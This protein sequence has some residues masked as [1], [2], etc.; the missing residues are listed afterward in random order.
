MMTDEDYV[1]TPEQIDAMLTYLPEFE[2]EGFVARVLRRLE[3]L[4]KG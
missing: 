2:R 1:P 4:R 3:V